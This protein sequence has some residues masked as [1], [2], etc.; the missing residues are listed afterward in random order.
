MNYILIVCVVIQMKNLLGGSYP[1][2]YLS[3]WQLFGYH[4]TIIPLE[5]TN[6][7]SFDAF[8][9]FSLRSKNL[10]TKSFKRRTIECLKYYINRVKCDSIMFLIL[11]C[12]QLNCRQ[13]L[14][15]H[16]FPFRLF[17]LHLIP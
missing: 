14:Y 8:Q 4:R 17:F 2:C 3:S 1:K 5:R 9:K 12:S 10:L 6:F 15:N 11:F 7:V 13:C 16:V